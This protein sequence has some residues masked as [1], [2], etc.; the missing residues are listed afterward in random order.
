MNKSAVL[1]LNS[2][3]QGFLL[4]RIADTALINPLLPPDGMMIYSIPLKQVLI[5]SN[6]Y[7][8]LMP[9]SASIPMNW[10]ATGN[11]G[12]DPSVHFLGTLDDKP[13][14]IKSN[15]QIFWEFGRRQTLG[16]TQNYP[17]Y[18]DP[19]ERVTHLRSALQFEAAGA[20]F[21]K[22]KMFVDANGNFRMKGS[23][24][25]TDYFE[26]GATGTNNNGGFEFVIGDDGDEPLVFKSYNFQPGVFTEIMRLQN[27]RMGLGTTTP[28]E[29]LDVLGNIRF[30]GALM[31]N[32]TAGT[33]GQ[34]L[35]SN[36]A[37]VAP[38]WINVSMIT[39]SN[40]AYGGNGVASMQNFGTTSN[41]A[42]PFV[43]NNVERMRLTTTGNLA[44]GNTSG[45]EKLDVT[46]NVKFS[47]ALMPNNTA[48]TGG[49]LLQSNGVNAAPTW[50]SPS[51][52][53]A[54]TWAYNGNTLTAETKFGT[55][56]NHALPFI[57][58][59]AERMRLTTTG[60]LAI[61]NALG[62]E[63]LDVTGNVKFS[64]A[65]M[66]NN[67]AGT[68]GQ[69][70]QSNG[71][72]S[73]PTWIS[74]T[75]WTYGGNGVTA[76][77]NLGTTTAY[78]LPIITSNAERMRILASNGNVGIANIAPTEKLDV[79]GNVKFSGALMPNNTAGT[80]GQLL[81]SNGVN[82]APTW[83]SPSS[84]I[85]S[86]WAYNGNTLTAETK[87]GTISNHALPFITANAE[88]MRLTTTGNLAI[89]NALGTER[90]DVTGN[91]K[92]SGALMPNNTAGT[93]GQLLQSN[94]AGSA[95]T[96]ISPTYW[97]YGGNGVTAM[98]NLG[99]TTAYDLPIITSNAERMRILASNG[100]VGIA[101]I[102]PTEKLDVT[103]N[104]KFS[105]ALM[106]NNSAGTSGYVLRSNGVN[107]APTWTDPAALIGN[108]VWLTTGNTVAALPRLGTNNAFDLP[109]YTNGTE[110]M[111]LTTTNRLGIAMTNPAEQLD[112]N[113]NIK[114]S[115]GQRRLVFGNVGGDP[116]A[117]IELRRYLETES[118]ELL[119]YSG[120]DHD[121]AFGPDRI[122]MVTEEFRVQ[123][124]GSDIGNLSAAETGN[125]LNNR[126]L[127]NVKGNVAIGTDQF[128]TSSPEKLLIDA[129]TTSSY[130]LVNARGS[131]NNYLQFNIQN[132]NAGNVASSDIVATANNGNESRHYIDMGINSSGFTD[133]TY[134]IISGANNAYLY[135]TGN[136]L[137]IGNA[138]LGRSVKIFSGGTATTNERIRIE[139]DGDVGIGTST[140][141]A[142]LDVQG[143]FKLGSIGTVL[144]NMIKGTIDLPYLSEFGYT[145]TRV[146]TI[147]IPNLTANATVMLNPRAN[148][149]TGI[150][151]GWSRASTGQLTIGFTNADT[152]P[153]AVSAMTYD[154]TIIQ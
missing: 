133:A 134:P 154:I 35:Q 81:Q 113:G 32:N 21:Y 1:E 28:S 104:V 129:G 44:I 42:I 75:Y 152:T 43:V 9:I 109:F 101:N 41:F 94:G 6:G 27:G 80:G 145:V 63:R 4:P 122:R 100:N 96:W 7:W 54:S 138:T 147:N 102:A 3:N 17:D 143:T 20:Q 38:T 148:L 149:P 19:N 105:G 24:A 48:G 72:G 46:G 62:T 33:T 115:G 85:A 86:T 14:I 68:G 136:D 83:I 69:L 123:G 16:L 116:D 89:G 99:T 93:G 52:I 55:I 36:G 53:I 66:P 49:Q 139:S 114:I 57:T 50:I 73:A 40:W 131:I 45:T 34:V 88:R 22:P 70:L 111:R 84:I 137:I 107:A 65:L 18:T 71:A 64:G 124:F 15:N 127:V 11:S 153:R 29:K 117:V 130:N 37:N 31:P 23:S 151:I 51:S 78:D 142:K 92:F 82:A 140:P 47:G 25:G 61:G 103:G 91:V 108:T 146:V 112:V 141:D 67:T 110:G 119:F 106:P 97:T 90:L 2:D 79:T 144:T 60:N 95:P 126:F 150:A 74:P 120:N 8:Q 121:N 5:R 128:N 12:T 56:S 30:S 10:Y 58:A 26:F 39:A 132:T 98:Q 135:S 59:N 13:M 77:Q 87:F 125:T 118:S 76:M